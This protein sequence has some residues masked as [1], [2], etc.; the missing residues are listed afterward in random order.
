MRTHQ[1]ALKKIA[2][3]HQKLNKAA[4]RKYKNRISLSSKKTAIR[5]LL[6]IAAE[7]ILYTIFKQIF[8]WFENQ[9]HFIKITFDDYINFINRYKML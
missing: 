5:F 4:Y 6:L 7:L 8:R 1:K 3:A 9:N 2:L